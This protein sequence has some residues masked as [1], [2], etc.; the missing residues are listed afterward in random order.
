VRTGASKATRDQAH[1][2]AADRAGRR[3]AANASPAAILAYIHRMAVD[4]ALLEILVCPACK[5]PVHLVNQGAG[6]K[7]DN[8]RRVYPIKDDIPVMLID[9]ATVEA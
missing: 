9:E 7:C 6:L 8:C 2:D 3:F 5:K 1:A 4:P